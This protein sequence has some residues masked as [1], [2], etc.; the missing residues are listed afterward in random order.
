MR[1]KFSVIIL[2]WTTLEFDKDTSYESRRYII[3]LRRR[4]I[5]ASFFRR[6]KFVLLK[7]LF[8][9]RNQLRFLHLG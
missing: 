5:T 4:K 2:D 1:S 9:S 8:V 6:Y 7:E 3:L